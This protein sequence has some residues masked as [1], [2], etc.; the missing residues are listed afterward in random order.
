MEMAD[1][2]AGCRWVRQLLEQ[3]FS[4]GEPEQ[5]EET[6]SESEKKEA[7]TQTQPADELLAVHLV[8]LLR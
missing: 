6:E 4:L 3:L 1:W 8:C 5:Q 2:N 7:T